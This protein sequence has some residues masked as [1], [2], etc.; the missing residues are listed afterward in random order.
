[1]VG[2]AVAV[3]METG[4]AVD[5]FTF[6]GFGLGVDVGNQRMGMNVLVEL[7]ITTTAFVAEGMIVGCSGAVAVG[8]GKGVLVICEAPGVRKTWSQLGSVRIDRSTGGMNPLGRLVRKSLFGL[9]PDCILA[10]NFQF[11]EE[12]SAQPPA[13]TTHRNPIN[14][15]RRIMIQSF[16]SRSTAFMVGSVDWQPHEDCC[17]RISLFVVARALEPNTPTMSIHDAARDRQPKTRTT[18]FEFRLT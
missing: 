13:K 11:G 9:M 6:V 16:R 15:M 17:A 4:V 1:M 3:A 2:V 12:R 10:F 7:A 8:V 18:A 5:T 14:N